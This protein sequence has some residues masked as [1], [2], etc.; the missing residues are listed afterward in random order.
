MCRERCEAGRCLKE[1]R[2]EVKG[3][4]TGNRNGRAGGQGGWQTFRKKKLAE[5]PEYTTRH[6]PVAGEANEVE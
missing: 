5:K 2:R 1:R 3:R 4:E 6:K